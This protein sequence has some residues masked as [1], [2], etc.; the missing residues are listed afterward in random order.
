MHK[1]NVCVNA[2]WFFKVSEGFAIK[3]QVFNLKIELP[4]ASWGKTFQRW[5]KLLKRL[6]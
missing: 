5:K 2:R 3:V 4:K 1:E 6:K